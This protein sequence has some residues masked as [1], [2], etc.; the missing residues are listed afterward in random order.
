MGLLSKVRSTR[1]TRR[2]AHD[3]ALA[4]A[5]ERRSFGKPIIEHQAVA[6]RLADTATSLHAAELMAWRAA[7]LRDQGKR[8]L[9]E[10]SRAKLFASEAAE[11]IC[12]DA[13]Q[14]HCRCCGNWRSLSMTP[15]LAA[16]D[17]RRHQRRRPDQAKPASAAGTDRQSSI[18]HPNL[19][20]T[21]QLKRN[22]DVSQ[23][24]QRRPAGRSRSICRGSPETTPASRARECGEYE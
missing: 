14:A 9:K 8:F 23:Q 16:L 10:A 24:P 22:V 19:P 11:R 17:R 21:I 1:R 5:K 3:V 18:V 2:S 6:F 7:S 20:T 12:R 4:Y 13:I 15:Y